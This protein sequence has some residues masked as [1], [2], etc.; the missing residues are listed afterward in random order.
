M[1]RVLDDAADELLRQNRELRLESRRERREVVLFVS[2]EAAGV[3]DFVD[4]VSKGRCHV[5]SIVKYHG[6]R[7]RTWGLES[8][9]GAEHTRV[10]SKRNIRGQ[11]TGFE[12]RPTPKRILVDIRACPD[13]RLDQV[14]N[15]RRSFCPIAME[16]GV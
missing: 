12:W 9:A 8:C 13:E 15:T 5:P 4:V 2:L 16:C 3:L 14:H 11:V 6:L 1:E 10:N 7:F